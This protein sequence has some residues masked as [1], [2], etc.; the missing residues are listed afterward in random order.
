VSR[1]FLLGFIALGGALAVLFAVFPLWDLEVAQVFFDPERARFPLSVAY[2]WNLVRQ[3]ANWVPFLL[4]AP[5]VFALLRKLVFP[6][7]K[8]PIAPSVVL[9]LIGSFLIGP[10]VASN[11]LLK[12]N[13]GRPRPNGVQQFAG[14]ADFQPWWRPSDACKRNCSFVS[15]EASEA[16]W[17]VAP[18]TLAPPQLRPFALGGAVIFGTAVGSLRVVF[19]RHFVSDIVFAGLITIAI[20]FALYR[21]LLDPVRRNDARLERGLERVSIG[22]HRGIA[23]VLGGAGRAL[24]SAGSSLHSTGQ[25]LHKRVACL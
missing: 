17:T 7:P 23:A 22:L 5:T 24:A 14:T 9:Y 18:A 20:V 8:M 25:H 3:A 6:D 12:E 16:F 13:W 11:L 4:L 19:G 21:L 10:G 2:E 15:G 1:G